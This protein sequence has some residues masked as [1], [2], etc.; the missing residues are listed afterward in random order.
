MELVVKSVSVKEELVVFGQSPR[1]EA[2]ELL[3]G[4][5]VEYYF[6]KSCWKALFEVKW[7]IR[8]YLDLL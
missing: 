5:A 1:R 2:L 7:T 4:E 3:C 8:K 6:W